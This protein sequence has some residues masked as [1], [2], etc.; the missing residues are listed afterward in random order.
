MDDIDGL[1][2]EYASLNE[3]WYWKD[4]VLDAYTASIKDGPNQPLHAMAFLKLLSEFPSNGTENTPGEVVQSS[5]KTRSQ[6]VTLLLS[7]RGKKL[8]Y[9][10]FERRRRL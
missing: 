2:D 7:C 1:L 6:R 4:S 5:W 8:E 10:V 3:L 9:N